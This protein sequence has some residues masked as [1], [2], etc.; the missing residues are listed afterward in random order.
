[1]AGE[2]VSEKRIGPGDRV[3]FR[4][5]VLAEGGLVDASEEPV[6]IIVGEGRF[7]PSVEKALLGHTEGEVLSVWVPPDEHYGWYDPRKIQFLPVEKIPPQ[8]RPGETIFVPDELGVLHPARLARRDS[9]VA[10]VDLN[11][12]LAGKPLRFD[13]EILKVEKIS[14][15]QGGQKI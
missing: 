12:P 8:A 14:E 10:V 4:Y 9:R 13:L 2:V 1:M 11:H 6:T 15:P 3:S 5:R 7:P